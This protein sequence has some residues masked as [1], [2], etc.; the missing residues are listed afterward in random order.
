MAH[1]KRAAKRKG[2][3]VGDTDLVRDLQRVEEDLEVEEEGG[4]KLEA[5][6]LKEEREKG[7]FDEEGNYVAREEKEE[8][9]EADAWLESEEGERGRTHASIP[10]RR[11]LSP[12]K[13]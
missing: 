5:F 13:G 4:M 12:G 8:D 1:T 2:G 10:S 6:N 7:Y 9:E 3:G 11:G